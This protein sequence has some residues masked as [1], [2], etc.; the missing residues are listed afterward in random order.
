MS[1]PTVVIIG[2]DGRIVA[3]HVGYNPHRGGRDLRDYL[4]KAGI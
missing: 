1:I 2:R 3:Y 4:K